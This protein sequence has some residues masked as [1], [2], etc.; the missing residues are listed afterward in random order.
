ME[1]P[2]RHVDVVLSDDGNGFEGAVLYVADKGS[3]RLM[4][5]ELDG[6]NVV[7]F[8][9]VPTRLLDDFR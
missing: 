7:L 8:C 3:S 1:W 5:V 2:N 6:C 4:A 9:D